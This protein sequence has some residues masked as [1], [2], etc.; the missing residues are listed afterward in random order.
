MIEAASSIHLPVSNK[1]RSTAARST[2]VLL[3]NITPAA[4]GTKHQFSSVLGTWFERLRGVVAVLQL[5]QS[6]WRGKCSSAARADLASHLVDCTAWSPPLTHWEDVTQM[7][8]SRI[9]H[10][11]KDDCWQRKREWD[12]SGH[13][14]PLGADTNF[15][16]DNILSLALAEFGYGIGY[17]SPTSANPRGTGGDC[18]FSS[19]ALFSGFVKF[20][21]Q[22]YQTYRVSLQPPTPE[23]AVNLP[24]FSIGLCS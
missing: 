21:P 5:Y 16:C 9:L 19:L 2:S 12:D 8:S 17:L 14:R 7:P 15:F 10:V 6:Q 20:T 11:A 18:M 1:T 23:Y 22:L 13:G 4:G 24:L 3:G